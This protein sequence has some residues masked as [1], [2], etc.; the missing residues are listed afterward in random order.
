VYTGTLFTANVSFASWQGKAM[1]WQTLR[2]RC[3]NKSP[4]KNVQN[5]LFEHKLSITW[6]KDA[7]TLQST[8]WIKGIVSRDFAVCFLVS[9][10]RSEVCI[11]AGACVRLLLKFRFRNEF[12]NFRVAYPVSGAGQS[13]QTV[14]FRRFAS[15][16]NFK[17]AFD[18]NISATNVY[19]K[20]IF[21]SAEKAPPLGC[22][23][24][25][26]SIRNNRKWNR[27]WFRNYPKQDVCFGCFGSI[28][29]Q[30][31]SVFR[32]NRNKKKTTETNRKK[33]WI[34]ITYCIFCN[35]G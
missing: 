32:L 21:R 18:K 8:Q 35:I 1:C 33:C 24:K 15:N 11:H 27:N 14:L 29:N 13:S 6:I 25:L 5:P 30:G 22:P 20:Q 10:D 26:I 2:L 19:I 28:S 23:A 17:C 16:C 4:L 9:F 31:V 12:F 7:A 34:L 3:L